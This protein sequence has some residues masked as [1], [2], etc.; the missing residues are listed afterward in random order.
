MAPCAVRWVFIGDAI[1]VATLSCCAA[2][3]SHMAKSGLLT[4][5]HLVHPQSAWASNGYLWWILIDDINLTSIWHLFNLFI[6]VHILSIENVDIL[7]IMVMQ[8]VGCSYGMG[9][10]M[11]MG[12]VLV[13]QQFLQPN[14]CACQSSHFFPFPL[15]FMLVNLVFAFYFTWLWSSFLLVQHGRTHLNI[16]D[17]VF[18]LVYFDECG[19]FW[20]SFQ[21]FL[22]LL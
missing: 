9:M 16:S 22:H 11:G 4:W 6:S 1:C 17:S 3:A 13:L 21:D 20:M 18:I 14:K 12:L 7:G 10:G 2:M 19:W 8:A 15:V 5:V